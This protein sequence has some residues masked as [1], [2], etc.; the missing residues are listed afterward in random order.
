MVFVCVKQLVN[1]VHC[2]T[3]LEGLASAGMLVDEAMLLRAKTELE[4]MRGKVDYRTRMESI[5]SAVG[6]AIKSENVVQ[7]EDLI[8]QMVGL[9]TDGKFAMTA[10]D[11]RLLDE[12]RDLLHDLKRKHALKQEIDITRPALQVPLLPGMVDKLAK[13]VE[14]M[15][16]LKEAAAEFPGVFT[17]DDEELLK[18]ASLNSIDLKRKTEKMKEAEMAL[19]AAMNSRD[20]ADLTRAIALAEE[21]PFIEES[22]LEA[23][24]DLAAFLDPP[25]RIATMKTA[26][27]SRNIPEIEKALED[28]KSA[29]VP[30]QSSL[31]AKAVR[32]LAKLKR[33][34]KKR[35]R[36]E[37]KRKREAARR[38]AEIALLNDK[39]RAAMDSKDI[40]ILQ[41][42][43]DVCEDSGY[44]DEEIPLYFAAEELFEKMTIENVRSRLKDGIER[45]DIQQLE[46][47]ID[48]ADYGG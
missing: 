29:R 20:Y 16:R 37:Q 12:S 33:L 25:T 41:D 18:T 48:D 14:T 7:L 35:K 34:E 30:G 39:L 6:R 19:T 43:L 22:T 27:A 10:D 32:T 31:E 46:T 26:I 8:D 5:K 44:R 3:A 38:D 42:A 15:Q 11:S 4:T 9:S 24:R 21:A 23:A 40:Y 17:P 36:A 1:S 45:R 2:F 28:F 47:A 13:G